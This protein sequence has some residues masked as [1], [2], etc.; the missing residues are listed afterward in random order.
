[1]ANVTSR[2]V[3]WEVIAP[4]VRWPLH[5]P[6]RLVLCVV[7]GVVAM[8]L[9]GSIGG[10]SSDEQTSESTSS[11]SSSDSSPS[12]EESSPSSSPSSSD[13]SSSSSSATSSGGSDAHEWG[14]SDAERKR[15][16]PAVKVASRLADDLEKH[17]SSSRSK[18]WAAVSPSLSKTGRQ[19]LKQQ[20]PKKTGFTKVTGKPGLYVGNVDMGE[21]YARVAIPTDKGTYLALVEKEG[22]SWKV[23][24]LSRMNDGDVTTETEGA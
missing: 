12:T 19:Q 6:M 16:R 14:A 15:G 3:L 2:G 23:A 11:S 9:V 13:S 8:C 7:A 17:R 4:V 10:S 1:M 24:S 21:R 20:G 18:W 22:G 5:S